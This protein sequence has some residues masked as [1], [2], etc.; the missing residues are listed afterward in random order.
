MD[1][2]MWNYH[3]SFYE[4]KNKEYQQKVQFDSNE[5][6]KIQKDHIQLQKNKNILL[7]FVEFFFLGCIIVMTYF[8]MPRII[9]PFYDGIIVGF[10]QTHPNP[11]GWKDP[12]VQIILPNHKTE[13][14]SNY[15]AFAPP[16]IGQKVPKLH[17]GEHI[18]VIHTGGRWIALVYHGFV[19]DE[20]HLL[21]IFLP[22]SF[23]SLW[24]GFKPP[25]QKVKK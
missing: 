15:G 9:G 8:E 10:D 24:L 20:I 2:F 7:I 1:Y 12:I 6:K 3:F 25:S 13:T 17:I 22:F 19:S 11:S 16:G 5:Q 23:L 14:F 18:R 21:L 4:K